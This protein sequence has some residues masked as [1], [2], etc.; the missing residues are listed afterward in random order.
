MRGMVELREVFMDPEFTDEQLKNALQAC[1]L[2]VAN[3]VDYLTNLQQQV[4][5][6]ELIVIETGPKQLYFW[7]YP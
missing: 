2:N 7:T 3:A 6:S 4:E 1:D 5:I